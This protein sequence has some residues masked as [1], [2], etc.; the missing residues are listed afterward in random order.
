MRVAIVGGAGGVG[1]STAF[2][3]ALQRTPALARDTVDALLG[4]DL[5]G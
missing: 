5:G 4:V 3:L 1:A 2:N